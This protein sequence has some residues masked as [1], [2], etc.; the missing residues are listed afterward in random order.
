LKIKD[1]RRTKVGTIKDR[2]LRGNYTKEGHT[3]TFLKQA[4]K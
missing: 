4:T 1:N 2:F 3:F